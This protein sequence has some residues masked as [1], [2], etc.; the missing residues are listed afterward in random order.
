VLARTL[1]M[2][3]DFLLLDEPLSSLDAQLREG[4]RALLRRLN[5]EGLT[6][7]HIT[8]DFE[9]TIS[10]AKHLAVLHDGSIVQQGPP[11]EVFQN[12][13]NEFV[14]KMTGIKNYFNVSLS[15]KNSAGR[16]K[17][18]VQNKIE[19]EMIGERDNCNGNILIRRRDIILSNQKPS[20]NETN[21]FE[22]VVKEIIPQR[23]GTDIIV[24]A[25][26]LFTAK[27]SEKPFYELSLDIGKKVWI[28]IKPEVIRFLS[29]SSTNQQLNKST[30]LNL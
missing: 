25:G 1:A 19:L 18:S 13:G 9:E 20:G 15:Q 26:V 8:H 4:L 14:A 6:I 27:L 16:V 3:P 2:E 5:R 10:L 22:G 30:K 23:T 21:I 24:D 11:K 17:A 28:S 7:I 29:F 12:P